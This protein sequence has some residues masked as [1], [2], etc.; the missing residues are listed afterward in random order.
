MNTI[1]YTYELI[2]PRNNKIFYIGKGKN[3]RMYFHYNSVKNG[4]I[5]VNRHLYYKIKQ[6]IDNNLEPIYN[7]IFES[8]NEKLCLYYEVK[9][10][11]EIGIENICNLTYGGE[12]CVPTKETR[13]KKSKSM[14]GK[15]IQKRTKETKEKMRKSHIG[16]EN[17]CSDETRKKISETMIK[18]GT[19]R[20]KNNPMYGKGYLVSGKKSGRYG[21]SLYDIWLKKYGIDLADKKVEIWKEKL[22]ESQWKKKAK[23]NKEK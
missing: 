22:S 2:D 4:N 1:F 23:K 10:I 6:L 12:G 13:L 20:G 11:K 18:N 7:K 17:P 5:L 19:S 21:K 15:N 8:N 14:M 3:N 16:K 9:Q